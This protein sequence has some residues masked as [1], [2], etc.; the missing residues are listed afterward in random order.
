MK[1]RFH[2]SKQQ[3]VFNFGYLNKYIWESR[4]SKWFNLFISLDV[5]VDTVL[6][7]SSGNKYEN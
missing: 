6:N 4:D 7:Y 5:V 2:I 3:C 1:N